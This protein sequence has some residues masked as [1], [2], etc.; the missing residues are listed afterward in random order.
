MQREMNASEGCHGCGKV[1]AFG[2]LEL[3]RSRTHD[4]FVRDRA[5]VRSRGFP[6]LTIQ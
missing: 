6:V 2:N 1:S 5:W 3:N 4:A